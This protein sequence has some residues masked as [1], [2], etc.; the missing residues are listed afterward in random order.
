MSQPQPI[1]ES[2][3]S[4][5]ASSPGSDTFGAGNNTS[6]WDAA[7]E[8]AEECLFDR[9]PSDAL[10]VEVWEELNP[11]DPTEFISPS[12]IIDLLDGDGHDDYSMDCCDD[13]PPCTTDEQDKDLEDAVRKVVGEWLDRHNLRPTWKV[14]GRSWVVTL[15]QAK[16]RAAQEGGAS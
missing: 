4:W 3:K 13:W 12:R 10:E 5:G 6:W 7:I 16:A 14:G 1:D 11:E 2:I 8:Y 15:G 9:E